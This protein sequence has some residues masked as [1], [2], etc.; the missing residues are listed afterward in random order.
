MEGAA[1]GDV[2]LGAVVVGDGGEV[3]GCEGVV[4]IV[5]DRECSFIRERD[6]LWCK[7]CSSAFAAAVNAQILKLSSALSL[8]VMRWTHFAQARYMYLELLVQLRVGTTWQQP[9][10]ICK[11]TWVG[12]Y[13]SIAAA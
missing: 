11:C 6:G 4:A 5:L 7:R 1:L 13:L 3:E 2:E 10:Y 9:S 8:S 12:L